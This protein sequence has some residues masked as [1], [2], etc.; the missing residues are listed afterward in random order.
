MA[1]LTHGV[2]EPRKNAGLFENPE[3]DNHLLEM[4]E[5]IKIA[6]RLIGCNASPKASLMMLQDDDAISYVAHKL[7]IATCNWVHGGKRGTHRGYLGQC[8]RWAIKTWTSQTAVLTDKTWDDISLNTIIGNED[9]HGRNVI[10]VNTIEDP[11][12]PDPTDMEMPLYDRLATAI[13][14]ADLTERE[15]A[16]IDLVHFKQCT[17]EQ[18]AGELGV[19]RERIKQNLYKAYEKIREADKIHGVLA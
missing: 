10:L 11:S 14:N 13:E 2:G 1:I 12:A 4:S 19:S 9:S 7:M 15:Q 6:K 17:Y 16:V 5:Y 3:L 18:V 8:G